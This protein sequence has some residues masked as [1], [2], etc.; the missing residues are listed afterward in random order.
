MINRTALS[1]AVI[2]MYVRVC[3]CER[4]LPHIEVLTSLG[5]TVARTRGSWYCSWLIEK[6]TTSSHKILHLQSSCRLRT[7]P[8]SS[9]LVYVLESLRKSQNYSLFTKYSSPLLC[10]LL[11]LWSSSNIFSVF[12]GENFLLCNFRRFNLFQFLCPFFSFLVH[13]STL[14]V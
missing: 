5:N 13:L 9:V 4:W 3:V 14:L 10:G 2:K 11:L 6:S 12:S 7:C 1:M 8:T